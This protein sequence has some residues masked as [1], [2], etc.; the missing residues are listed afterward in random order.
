M[1]L[2]TLTIGD[3]ARQAGVR[4][5]TLRYY[6]SI[7]LLPAPSRVSGRRRYT[8]DILQRLA[9]I[10]L[11]RHAG[12]SIAQMQTLFHGFPSTTSPAERWQTLASQKLIEVSALI[13]S[14]Q[15]MQDLLR[16]LLKCDCC[17]LED[18][19]A[20]SANP[21]GKSLVNA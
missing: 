3:I 5:S 2:E 7:G 20:D 4:P 8:P 10:R 1:E 14:A 15:Q 11:A 17:Q 21:C 9:V 19:A 6:E 13:A 16:T 12:F 18:C